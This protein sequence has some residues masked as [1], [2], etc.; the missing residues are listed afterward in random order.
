[1]S[2]ISNFL[3]KLFGGKPAQQAPTAGP[4]TTHQPGD[5]MYTWQQERMKRANAMEQEIKDWLVTTIKETGNLPFSW[6]SGNDEAFITFKDRQET[7]EE[8]FDTLEQ[9]ILLKLDIPDA[10]EFNMTGEGLI[11]ID[12]DK[13]KAKFSSL[14]KEVVDYD[15]ETEQ[16]TYGEEVVNTGE[17]LLFLI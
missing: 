13:V 4:Q 12:N 5:F 17:E 6:E 11:Y 9:Y 3:Q 1:M 10:G 7:Q 16:E 2:I 8:E 15:E 14:M